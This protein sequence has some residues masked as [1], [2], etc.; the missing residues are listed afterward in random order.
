MKLSHF[1]ARRLTLAGAIALACVWLPAPAP[2]GS[3]QG[4]VI[5]LEAA[6]GQLAEL[7]D[8]SNAVIFVSGFRE[9]PP[10]DGSKELRQ[11]NKSFSQRVLAVSQGE[12]VA[13]PNMDSIHHNVWSKSKAKSF[14]LGLFKFPEHKTV[15]F[16]KPGMVTVFCNIHAKM[17]ATIL[18]L[19]NTRH[20][21][22]AA[23][24]AY[25]IEGI[26]D[27]EYPVYAWVEGAR[28]QKRMV[29]FEAGKTAELDF[30]LTLRRIPLRHLNKEGKPYKEY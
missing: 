15:T 23:S 18:V 22:T 25:R 29:R 19:P 14:D 1:P 11:K 30:R 8:P 9:P 27:G 21:I 6:D 28:P 10:A 5:V 3:L 20:A 17:I 4:R 26:P 13:F 24:G 16:E 7:D 2:G 12:S